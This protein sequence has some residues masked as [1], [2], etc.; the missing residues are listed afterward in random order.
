MMTYTAVWCVPSRA[1]VG[2]CTNAGG[3]KNGIVADPSTCAS[4][5]ARPS[6]L[7]RIMTGGNIPGT[8]AEATNTSRRRVLAF[9]PP[10]FAIAPRSHTTG[11][12]VTTSVVATSSKRPFFASR[13]MPL[14]IVSLRCAST[15][16]RKGFPR[17]KLEP[18]IAPSPRDCSKSSPSPPAKTSRRSASHAGPRNA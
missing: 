14:I 8:L 12:P 16:C 11:M 5:W 13:A 1:S 18:N 10:F 17:Y 9:G 6:L 15:S 7:T 2:F 3:T 4:S